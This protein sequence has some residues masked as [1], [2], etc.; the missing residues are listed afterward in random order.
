MFPDYIYQ[1]I[2]ILAVIDAWKNNFG[3][4]SNQKTQGHK[5]Q[6]NNLYFKYQVCQMKLRHLNTFLQFRTVNFWKKLMRFSL[7]FALYWI[8]YSATSTSMRRIVTRYTVYVHLYSKICLKSPFDTLFKNKKAGK[9]GFLMK[10]R[11]QILRWHC[12]FTDIYRG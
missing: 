2:D 9:W 11:L 8:N 5:H 10:F 6:L 1:N 4:H 12:T 7:V 3:F